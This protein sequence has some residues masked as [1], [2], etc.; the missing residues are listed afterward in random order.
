MKLAPG[1]PTKWIVSVISSRFGRALKRNASKKCRLALAAEC[2][3]VEYCSLY[4]T[5]RNGIDPHAERRSL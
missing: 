1:E 2:E 3:A 4:G 5:G